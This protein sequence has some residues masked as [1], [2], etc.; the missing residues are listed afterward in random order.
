VAS[1]LSVYVSVDNARGTV[2]CD[3]ALE[4]C[5]I[6]MNAVFWV[7]AA[8]PLDR[9]IGG[10]NFTING[11]PWQVRFSFCFVTNWPPTNTRY[12]RPGSALGE[13]PTNVCC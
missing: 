10:A 2:V 1:Q 8:N 5:Q 12:I 13:S 4:I 7:Q 11:G 9:I 3:S 6:G